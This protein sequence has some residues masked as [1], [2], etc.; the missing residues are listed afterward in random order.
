MENKCSCKGHVHEEKENSKLE[1]ITTILGIIV[2]VS[3]IFCNKLNYNFSLILYVISYMLIGYEVL[4]DAIKN[5]LNKELFDENFLMTIATIGAFAIGEY[6]EAISVILLYKIG[7]F[8]Q[9]KAA[10]NSRRKISEAVDI[11]LNIAWIKTPEGIKKIDAK[12]LKV[13][14][15]IVVKTGEKIPVDCVL[16]SDIA[17]LDMSSLTG[18]SKV[19]TCNKKDQ[20]LSGS[21]NKGG[22]ITLKVNKTFE[23]SAVSKIMELIENSVE[24]KSNTEKFIT[25]FAKIYTPIVT[26]LAVVIALLPL[27]FEISFS[28]SLHRAFSFLVISCPCALVI[29]VPLGFFVGIGASSKKGILVKGSNY[30]DILSD[31][32]TIVFD[33][34]GTLTKGVFDI[35]KI[36]SVDKMSKDGILKMVALCEQFSNH[37][38]AK[39]I[40]KNYP[41]DIDSKLVTKHEEIAGK[42]II[43]TI[44]EKEVIVGNAN[45]LNENGVDFKNVNE[46]GT[47]VYLAINGKFEGYVVL[48]DII[49]DES[50]KLIEKLYKSGIKRCVMLTGDSEKIAAAVANELG[51]TEVHSKLLPEE[52]LTELEK[53]KKEEPNQ[54]VAFVGDGINDAPVLAAA[55]IGISMGKGSDLAIETSD[56][57]LINDNPEKI[58]DAIKI[59]R[60]TK[61]IV[62]QNIIFAI[63]VK[64]LFLVLSGFGITSMW[65]AIFADVGVAIITIINSIRIFRY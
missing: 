53:I 51:I 11:R 63:I 26:F 59:S 38:I 47:I 14:D 18:E 29:S 36:V 22:I 27:V 46:N 57:V 41:S 40:L 17:K 48:S 32:K 24:K 19:V 23:N 10:E 62:K 55:D 25:R 61:G 20:I 50:K 3:A 64:V 31:T 35:S 39:S 43:S 7:E 2:F 13:G 8:L 56:V 54:K 58:I 12:E 65:F 45:L 49:K 42:G 5:I 33:K 1:F 44:D 34:T 6:T 37:Y 21:L 28:E 15:E 9:D 52:K 30:L 4:Y 16:I 60:R